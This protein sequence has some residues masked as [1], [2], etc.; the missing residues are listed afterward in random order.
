[1]F[2][3]HSSSTSSL[4]LHYIGLFPHPVWERA[5]LLRESAGRTQGSQPQIQRLCKNGSD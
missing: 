1:M 4:N 5:N 3:K 2:I